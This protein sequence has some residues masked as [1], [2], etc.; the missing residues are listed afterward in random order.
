[1]HPLQFV[2]N[3][4]GELHMC[5]DFCSLN[6]QTW[7]DMFPI[8]HIHDL[9][10]KLGKARVFSA[11]DLSSVLALASVDAPPTAACAKIVVLVGI[12]AKPRCPSTT[13]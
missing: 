3:K 10:D 1:M 5:V 7:L 12:V 9:L 4:M 6:H 2:H 8:P 11:I 13:L